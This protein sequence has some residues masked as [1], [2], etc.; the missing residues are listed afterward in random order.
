MSRSKLAPW[1][2][3]PID[4]VRDRKFY[5]YVLMDPRKPGPFAY[6]GR[7]YPY[8]PFYIGKGTGYRL[9]AHFTEAKRYRATGY[10]KDDVEFAKVS[11]ILEIMDSG[12]DEKT[13]K[14]LCAVKLIE[15]LNEFEAFENETRLITDIGRIARR[16]GPLVNENDGTQFTGGFQKVCIP[17]FTGMNNKTDQGDLISDAQNPRVTPRVALNVDIDRNG[18]ATK[19]KGFRLLV[20]LPGARCLWSCRHGMFV[21]ANDNDPAPVGGPHLFRIIGDRA[22]KICRINDAEDCMFFGVDLGTSIFFSSENDAFFYNVAD[23]SIVYEL[24]PIP[25]APIAVPGAVGSLPKGRYRLCSTNSLGSS[26]GAPGPFVDVHIPEDGGC[27]D[28]QN[29]GSLGVVWMTEPNGTEFFL[30]KELTTITTTPTVE[31]LQTQSF[32]N[33]FPLTFTAMFLGRLFGA[34]GKRLYYSEA[35][36]Y[37]VFHVK[38]FYEFSE[39]ITMVAPAVGLNGGGVFVG[40]E[41]RTVFL[42]GTS[43]NDFSEKFSGPQPLIGSLAYCH[44]LPQL[45]NNVPV[46][47]TKEGII[48]GA[49]DGSSQ[50]ITQDKMRLAAGL[51]G[52]S[53]FRMYRGSPQI[54]SAFRRSGNG[55]N[56]GFGDSAT[57]EVIRKGTVLL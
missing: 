46:W 8:E 39:N 23:G 19:R 21:V 37:D 30:S 7:V 41:T 12:V 54:V 40:L 10:I 43:V 31:P 3:T 25:P 17:G 18:A 22:I 11:K 44:N 34:V 36:R 9:H 33:T 53:F 32:V 4:K 35:Y 2:D 56:V 42:A 14:A 48:A 45:G 49:F 24:I 13:F 16:M 6:A 51:T 28:I 52:A 50:N 55:T 20:D 15:N 29:S 27:I 1:L 57:C 47:V 5:C 38:N 26:C